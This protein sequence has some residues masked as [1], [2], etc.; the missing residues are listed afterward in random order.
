MGY[1]Q[2]LDIASIAIYNKLKQFGKTVQGVHWS[3]IA[4]RGTVAF[5][6]NISK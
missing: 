3:V 1:F 5:I 2:T 4:H 6:E